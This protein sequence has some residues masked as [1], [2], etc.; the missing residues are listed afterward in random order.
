ME[1]IVLLG[2]GGHSKSVVDTIERQGKY[3]IV[4]FLDQEMND[5][6][7][8]REYGIVGRDEHLSDFYAQGVRHAFVSIGYLGNSNTRELLYEKII[9]CGMTSPVIIDPSAV[10]SSDA[11]VGQGV[12]IGKNTVVN[13]EAKIGDLCILNTGSIVEHECQIGVNTH[14][15]VGSVICGNTTIGDHTFIG[16]NT[17]VIQGIQ[18]GERVVIG[19]GMLVI[20]HIERYSKFTQ[21]TK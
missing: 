3:E 14:I 2:C 18:I 7:S 9:A 5:A 17:T 21:Y 11:V 6:Y 15:S 16:A 19:A 1:Q 13:A 4:G 12:F 20:N 8:Y 10:I